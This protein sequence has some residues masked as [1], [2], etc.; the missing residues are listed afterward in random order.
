MQRQKF[1]WNFIKSENDYKIF[2]KDYYK[3]LMVWL[4]PY[5]PWYALINKM[6]LM[7]N[8]FISPVQILNIL[9]KIF[10]RNRYSRVS[11]FK[12]LQKYVIWFTSQMKLQN[13]R[14]ISGLRLIRGTLLKIYAICVNVCFVWR[15]HF[16][17]GMQVI[18]EIIVS[19]YKE[20]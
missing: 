19:N 15:M 20:H 6:R 12:L 4:N 14:K 17:F 11:A 1:I 7:H 18:F 16:E 5:Y 8:S 2:I 13:K 3:R 10:T 9:W